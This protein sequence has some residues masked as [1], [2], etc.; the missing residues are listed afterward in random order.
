VRPEFLIFVDLQGLIK[1]VIG[2]IVD[3]TVSALERIITN[4]RL[5]D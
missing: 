1:V 3:K 2:R 4:V 5:P